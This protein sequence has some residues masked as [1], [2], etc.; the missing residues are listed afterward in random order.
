MERQGQWQRD[1]S[2]MYFAAGETIEKAG[3]TATSLRSLSVLA[4]SA[5]KL[6]TVESCIRPAYDEHT[7]GGPFCWTLRRS[8]WEYTSYPG[9]TQHPCFRNL[10][11]W[12][13][14]EDSQSTIGALRSVRSVT[15]QYSEPEWRVAADLRLLMCGHEGI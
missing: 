10:H 12:A 3:I 7:L 15:R 1:A 2:V 11:F 4:L 14:I 6:N 13:S 5:M 9:Q 8:V